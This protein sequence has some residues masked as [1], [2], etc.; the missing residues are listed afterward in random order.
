[1]IGQWNYTDDD[2]HTITIP[3]QFRQYLCYMCPFQQTYVAGRAAPHAG[4]VQGRPDAAARC[5]T[6]SSQ[7]ST[8]EPEGSTCER[9]H[10]S[11]RPTGPEFQV[12]PLMTSQEAIVHALVGAQFGDLEFDVGKSV[13]WTQWF[14]DDVFITDVNLGDAAL[15]DRQLGPRR[16]PRPTTPSPASTTSCARWTSARSSSP[17]RQQEPGDPAWSPRTG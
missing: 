6:P 11:C 14:T 2:G 13:R 12:G 1:M 15:L 7:T 4:D 5:A 17:W 3:P 9:R 10:R 8:S 16:S